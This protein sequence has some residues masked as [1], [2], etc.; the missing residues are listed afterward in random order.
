MTDLHLESRVGYSESHYILGKVKIKRI[1]YI[2][3][4]EISVLNFLSNGIL[5]VVVNH[6]GWNADI[7]RS[8]FN[9]FS[10]KITGILHSRIV[11][12]YT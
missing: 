8:G 9:I 7:R 3:M 5:S 6:V 10:I 11:E 2:S 12:S 1:R 4:P